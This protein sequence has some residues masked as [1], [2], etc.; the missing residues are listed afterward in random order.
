MEFVDGELPHDPEIALE[1]ESE[2]LDLSEEHLPGIRCLTSACCVTVGVED[3]VQTQFQPFPT[4]FKDS[5]NRTRRSELS[6]CVII[7]LALCWFFSS[8]G[9]FA[10]GCFCNSG[11]RVSLSEWVFSL[12]PRPSRLGMAAGPIGE[13]CEMKS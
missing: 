6:S 12:Q 11:L 5:S 10:K 4:M 2:V 8:F 13:P 3:E 9:A 7:V 1:T